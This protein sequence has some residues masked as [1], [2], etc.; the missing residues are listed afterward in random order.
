M[1]GWVLEAARGGKGVERCKDQAEAGREPDSQA[2][3]Y[4]WRGGGGGKVRVY[5]SQGASELAKC[6]LTQEQPSA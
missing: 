1:P 5:Q 2:M 6:T 4:R 3:L